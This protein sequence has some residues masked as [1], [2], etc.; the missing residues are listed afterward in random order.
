MFPLVWTKGMSRAVLSRQY[1]QV[2]VTGTAILAGVFRLF[3]PLIKLMLTLIWAKRMSRAVLS[4]QY[5]DIIVGLPTIL[6]IEFRHI[7]YVLKNNI[8]Y[9]N[10]NIMFTP[11]RQVHIGSFNV[12]FITQILMAQI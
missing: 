9:P 10:K 7:Q 1:S 12:F 11:T 3:S 4:R 2:T 8:L 6:T 5:S